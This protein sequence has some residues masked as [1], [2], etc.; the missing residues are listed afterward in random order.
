MVLTPRS[1]RL[2]KKCGASGIPDNKKCRINSGQNQ[3]DLIARAQEAYQ[4]YDKTKSRGVDIGR[5]I[6]TSVAALGTAY[7]AYSLYNSI[8]TEKERKN[9]TALQGI[10]FKRKMGNEIL[11]KAATR[12]RDFVNGNSGVNPWATRYGQSSAE[13]QAV[14]MVNRAKESRRMWREAARRELSALKSVVP[15]SPAR[16]RTRERNNNDSIW[17]DGFEV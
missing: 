3:S 2:D 15:E 11:V 9:Q 7:S 10:K 4:N 1:V 17:A 16:K 13:K 14:E 8:K 12:E 5:V 6:G